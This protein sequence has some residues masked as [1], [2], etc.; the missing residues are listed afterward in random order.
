LQD[1][2][3]NMHIKDTEIIRLESIGCNKTDSL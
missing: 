1:Y 3:H 2:G